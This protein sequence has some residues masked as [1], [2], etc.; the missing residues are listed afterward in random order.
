M[1][2]SVT[3]SVVPVNVELKSCVNTYLIAV[4]LGGEVY[5]NDAKEIHRL[6]TDPNIGAIE[7]QNAHLLLGRDATHKN[8]KGTLKGIAKLSK[9]HSI[10]S[11]VFYYSGHNRGGAYGSLR[12][13]GGDQLREIELSKLLEDIKSERK[14]L[15]LDCCFAV[16]MCPMKYDFKGG[17]EHATEDISDAEAQ[18]D[19]SISQDDE[20]YCMSIRQGSGFRMWAAGDRHE[21][22]A[23]ANEMNT[24]QKHSVF[25]K[26]IVAGL[27]GAKT[28]EFGNTCRHCETYRRSLESE[29]CVLFTKIA[30]FVYQHVDKELDSNQ[31]PKT[32]GLCDLEYKLAY[33]ACNLESD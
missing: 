11:L 4:G 8:I 12:C 24:N 30:D 5:K 9:E 13:H 2:I 31:N 28:C 1:F 16:H 23:G 29:K 19:E 14:L 7:K 18:A 26:Y 10:Q 15:I 25:T 3:S 6:F 32:M 33:A 27:Q 20:K 17:D 21:E 22:A